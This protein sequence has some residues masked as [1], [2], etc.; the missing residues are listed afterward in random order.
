ME[1]V[2]GGGGE[3]ADGEGKGLA[4]FI[5]FIVVCRCL[6]C[7]RDSADSKSQT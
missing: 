2:V 3:G 4:L 1:K 7:V 5:K 6:F